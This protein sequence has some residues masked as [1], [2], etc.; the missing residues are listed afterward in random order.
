MKGRTIARRDAL[1]NGFVWKTILT[2]TCAKSRCVHNTARCSKNCNCCL[3]ICWCSCLW[4]CCWLGFRIM[5]ERA[6]LPPGAC[7]FGPEEAWHSGFATRLW[8]GLSF[9]F[10]SFVFRTFTAF[11]FALW[12]NLWLISTFST[13]VPLIPNLWRRRCCPRLC[14]GLCGR[15]WQTFGSLRVIIGIVQLQPLNQA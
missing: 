12:I 10:P 5:K 6:T 9:G 7:P 15:I 1:Q 13:L 3:C 11:T 2:S 14:L 8:L 4:L